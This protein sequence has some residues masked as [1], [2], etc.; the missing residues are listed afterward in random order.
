MNKRNSKSSILMAIMMVLII[1]TACTLATPGFKVGPLQTESRSIEQV[2]AESVRAEIEIG[3]GELDVN[4]G[5]ADF[6]Q[7]DF[8]YNITE[9]KPE[10]KLSDDVLT[11]LTPETEGTASFWD[12]DDYRN[13]WDLH[14]NNNVP[15][16]MRVFLGAGRA[17]LNVGDLTLTRLDV[18]TGA[19]EVNLDLNGSSALTRLEITAGVGAVIVDL[20]GDWQTDL[21]A[22]IEAGVGELTLLL[23]SSACVR[24]T[25]EGG[26]NDTNTTGLTKDGDDYVNDAC[27]LSDVTLR[28]DISA[29]I[30]NI[31]LN[32]DD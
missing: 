10:V 28:I 31:N 22:G 12:L 11:I 18:D 23:P 25:V 14:F 26:I 3:A 32:L 20:T 21:N 13:E 4:G 5:V 27:G 7:A 6:L 16:E 15:M 9:L 2:D 29:G 30:G 24:V 8:I 19:G 1:S 17:N